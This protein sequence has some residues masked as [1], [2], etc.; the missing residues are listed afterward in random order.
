MV[1]EQR[2]NRFTTL[3]LLL[4]FLLWS[5]MAGAE[6]TVVTIGVL[7]KRGPAVVQQRWTATAAYLSQQI[8]EYTFTIVPLD[9]DA[10]FAAVAQEKIDFFI[11]NSSF[12]ME[13]EAAHGVSRIATL[14]NR[15]NDKTS[16]LFGG[17]IFTAISRTDLATLDDLKG[18]SFMAVNPRSFGGWQMAWREFKKAG[19][20]PEKDFSKLLFGETHDAVVRAVLAEKVDAGTVRTDTLE[21]MLADG[22]INPNDFRIINP[23]PPDDAF[24]FYRSTPLYPEWPFGKLQHTPPQLA[25]QVAVALLR[26]PP[27]APAAV[28]ANIA[29]WEVPLNYHPILDLMRELH[30]GPYCFTGTATLEE[31]IEHRWREGS[32]IIILFVLLLAGLFWSSFYGRRTKKLH[33]ALTAELARREE[34]EAKLQDHHQHLET[35]VQRRT[36]ELQQ[37]NLQ[38][39][40]AHERLEASQ[41]VAHLGC[42]EWQIPENTLW[43][44]TE[45]YRI[46]GLAPGE[47]NATLEGFLNSVHPNDR[48]TVQRAVAEAFSH[49]RDYDIEHRIVLPD[50]EVRIVQENGRVEFDHGGSPIRMIG[51]VQDITQRKQTEKE[52]KELESQLQHLHKIE[53]I[54]TLA[55]GIAHDFNN[56][57]TPILGYAELAEVSIAD[58]EEARSH[59]AEVI[60]A[61][62][63]AAALIRQILTFSRKTGVASDFFSP[64]TMVKESLKLLRASTPSSIEIRE[65]IN[66]DSGLI[67]TD[68]TKFQQV[69]VNICTNAVH[70]IE[71]EKGVITVRIDRRHLDAADLP[72]NQEMTPGEFIE[73]SISDTGCGMDEA[74]LRHIF[75]PYYTTKEPGRGTGLG[76]AIVHGIIHEMHGAVRVASEVGHGTT[77]TILI[78]AAEKGATVDENNPDTEFLPH[79]DEHIL[80]VDD[81]QPVL[82][83]EKLIME[84]L[85]YRVTTMQNSEEALA[86]FKKNPAAF[87]L[88]F[89]DQTMPVLTGKDLATAIL[90][91]RP[92]IPII[93][94]TGHSSMI[95]EESLKQIGVKALL[96]KPVSRHSMAITIRNLLNNS[97]AN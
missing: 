49:G 12:Y 18:H 19:I 11:T 58:T 23:Q 61:G 44:S 85:G 79:G 70:A 52:K 73:I 65:E 35:L 27:D 94:T 84:G 36:R 63:R 2:H 72:P 24:P 10:M 21:R 64:V 45:I 56:L 39:R 33:L 28:A 96:M 1:H 95:N 37:T 62:N 53:A 78:P 25:K 14:Q 7:A 17:V 15:L 16:T 5:R 68:P 41:R 6:P 82:L 80:V 8:P 4:L 93:I 59:I 91:I 89:T 26:M 51:T 32:A 30:L 48:R 81:E 69:I 47:F 57:L 34:A 43:W 46:F 55:G 66:N 38:S 54:G 97:P 60:K 71:N 13:L 22:S 75:E 20:D 3:I 90:A 86:E 74:T 92:E 29:G 77:F 76:L 31:I 88:I 42:W 67:H 9:F 87:D 40:K 50:G 83:A